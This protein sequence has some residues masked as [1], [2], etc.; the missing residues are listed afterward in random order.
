MTYLD[1]IYNVNFEGITDDAYTYRF[2]S[3]GTK[4]IT[5][6]VS[7][8]PIHG[9]PYTYNLGFGN[10]ETIDEA[11]VVSDTSIDNN[12]DS[13]KVLKTVFGCLCHFFKEEPNAKVIFFG[14]TEHKNII[15]KR[16]VCSH[17]LELREDFSIYGGIFSGPVPTTEHTY[18]TLKNGKTRIRRVKQKDLTNLS[19]L[20]E[21]RIE[22]FD[23]NNSKAC[24]F[25]IFSLKTE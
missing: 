23:T 2:I 18:M 1:D 10:L 12:T 22:V 20:P 13:A 16:M 25:L 5:K 17:L 24:D 14:N 19:Q 4:D 6:V 9:R 8:R 7:L 3:E 21:P 11:V 15:Y